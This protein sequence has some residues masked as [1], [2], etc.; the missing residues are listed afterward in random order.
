MRRSPGSLAAMS[1]E[2]HAADHAHDEDLGADTERFRRFARRDDPDG[3]LPAQGAVG[4]PFRLVTL[5]V[6]IAVLAAIVW[7]L[8]QL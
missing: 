4:V 5:V 8:F 7:L 2:L 3:T 6:G 1:D